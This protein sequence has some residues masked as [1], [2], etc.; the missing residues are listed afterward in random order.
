[1]GGV[2]KIPAAALWLLLGVVVAATPAQAL[3]NKANYYD[4][5]IAETNVTRLCHEQAILTVN[6]QFPG[7][8]I[9][10]RR[11]DVVFVNVHNRGRKNITLHWHGVD[12][13]RNPWFDGPEFI[14]Q[15]PIQPG[16]NFTYRIVFSDEEGTLW[17]HAHSD[18]DR[19]TVHGAIVVRPKLGS[20]YPYPEPHKDIPIILGEWWNVSVQHLLEETMRSGG[21]FNISDANTING[22]PGDLLPCSKKGTFRVP[23]ERGRTYMLR[24]INAGLTNDMFFAVAGH[25]LTVVGSDGH[26]LKPFTAA[27]IM[28]AAGQTMNVL[29]HADRAAD[30]SRYYMAARTFA[31]NTEIPVNNSTATAVLEYTDAPSSAGPPALPD[32][33]AVGDLPAAT[34]YT[35]QLLSLATDG[36]P[37][38][39]P[40]RVDERMLV[41]VSVNVLPCGA[42]ETCEGPI[43]GTRFAASL[44]NVSFV[45]PAVDILDAY[46]SSMRGVYEP[47]FPDRPPL[48]YNFT[49]PEPAQE[50]WF[51]KRGTKV[52]VVEYGA[53]VEVVFQGTAI[54]G[55]EPHPMHLHGF[56]FYTVGRGFGNF[57]GSKHP[58]KYNLVNPPRQ[59][60]VSVPAGGWAAIRFRATNPGVWFM[61]C[62]FDRHTVWGMDTVFIVKN[63][64]TPDAQ[65]LP[66]PPT[67]PKC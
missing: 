4:F 59:N 44:N 38:D 25:N 17:W 30:A 37:V 8:T 1:M 66:R 47:D 56:A 48:F 3:R 22:Q 10:A 46:Y 58:A 43:N 67:M 52:K 21:D 65:M 34:A 24:V 36:H 62:H 27:H 35:A 51:T 57:D 54:L 39:V 19:A 26:Y 18:F 13:P 60:T 15:C 33:P 16:A 12:Q 7:P 40:T 41:T 53:V 14:T 55:A 64:K 20:A 49:A 45:A 32:L 61:H 63:G 23:V 28:I 2:A 11:G 42:N 50:L 29:L 9:H 5:I 31:T 6:G